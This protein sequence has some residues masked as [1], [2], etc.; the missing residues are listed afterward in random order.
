MVKK[1]KIYYGIEDLYG[2]LVYE[3]TFAAAR[4]AAANPATK[5]IYEFAWS[6]GKTTAR[7]VWV[8]ERSVPEY[9]YIYN[10][11]PPKD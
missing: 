8:R 2:N 9:R 3:R 10:G 7:T 11:L 1:R 6:R 5:T 4:K